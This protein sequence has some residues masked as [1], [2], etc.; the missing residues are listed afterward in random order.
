[1]IR[2]KVRIICFLKGTEIPARI[3]YVHLSA[4][5]CVDKLRHFPRP[6]ERRMHSVPLCPTGGNCYTTKYH[7]R[8]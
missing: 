8:P 3:K 1:M 4:R 2:K 5:K 6:N 7:T